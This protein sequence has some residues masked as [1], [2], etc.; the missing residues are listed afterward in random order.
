MAMAEQMPPSERSRRKRST[1]R[2]RETINLALSFQE[3]GGFGLNHRRPQQHQPRSNNR[4]MGSRF[5]PSAAEVLTILSSLREASQ[6]QRAV[7]PDRARRRALRANDGVE[8][9]FGVGIPI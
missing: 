8:D 1:M 9:R 2:R 6:A 5:P 4:E 7:Q 3:A